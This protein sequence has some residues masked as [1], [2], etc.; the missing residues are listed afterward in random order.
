M[1]VNQW[2]DISYHFVI[3]TDGRIYQGRGWGRFGAIIDKLFHLS[4]RAIKM[5]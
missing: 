3:G 1:Q 4:A 2:P 5:T